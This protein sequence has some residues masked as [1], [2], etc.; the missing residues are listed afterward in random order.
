MADA[1]ELIEKDAGDKS[2]IILVSVYFEV[3]S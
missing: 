2:R 1:I 3:A